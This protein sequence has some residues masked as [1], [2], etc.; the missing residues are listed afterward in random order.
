MPV[1]K[2]SM[3]LRPRYFPLAHSGEFIRSL[4]SPPVRLR[5]QP[6]QLARQRGPTAC[7]PAQGLRGCPGCNV[8][9][10]F[11]LAGSDGDQRLPAVLTAG[12]G[13]GAPA[14]QRAH[15]AW[16]LLT[17]T[18]PSWERVSRSRLVWGPPTG[19]RSA[20]LRREGRATYSYP[21]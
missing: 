11:P 3:Q 20:S 19:S 1:W 12:K 13:I 8:A 14:P 17:L 5:N 10:T 18:C 21:F 9:P 6:G 2:T 15:L 16:D 7:L 4:I